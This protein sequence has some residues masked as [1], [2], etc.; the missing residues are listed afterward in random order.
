M[1]VMTIVYGLAAAVCVGYMTAHGYTPWPMA[2]ATFC[3]LMVLRPSFRINISNTWE[4]EEK[5]NE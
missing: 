3:I 4:Q 2:V 1:E 5:T